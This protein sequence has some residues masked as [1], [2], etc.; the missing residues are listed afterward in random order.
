MKIGEKLRKIRDFYG[1]TQQHIADEIGMSPSQYCKYEKDETPVTLETL[2]KICSI[3]K[4]TQV[5]VL[6]WD[7]RNVFNITG[8][9]IVTGGGYVH[10]QTVSDDSSTK[11]LI[12]QL[13]E[14]IS[15]LKSENKKLWE[16][17]EKLK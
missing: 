15:H 6:S 7:E 17:I 10:Q 5:D 1:Y 11:I 16:L 4:L 13:Q 12:T 2:E 3:Y 8:N 14:E 9:S